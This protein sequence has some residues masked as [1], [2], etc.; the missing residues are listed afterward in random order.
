MAY[1]LLKTNPWMKAGDKVEEL[2][3]AVFDAPLFDQFRYELTPLFP[4]Q[5]GS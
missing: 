4:E 3:F 5:A 1:W 2:Y